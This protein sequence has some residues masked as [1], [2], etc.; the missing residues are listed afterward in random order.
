MI[1]GNTVFAF[2]G[3][4]NQY[5]W[6]WQPTGV[7]IPQPRTDRRLILNNLTFVCTAIGPSLPE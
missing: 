7:N 3:G 6:S 2:T 4:A 5:A 1:E